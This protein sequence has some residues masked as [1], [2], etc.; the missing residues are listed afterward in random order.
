MSILHQLGAPFAQREIWVQLEIAFAS[1]DVIVAF[2]QALCVEA[3][4]QLEAW[5]RNPDCRLRVC[6]PGDELSEAGLHLPGSQIEIIDDQRWVQLIAG[7][8]HIQ[9]WS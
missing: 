4:A 9:H 5:A 8:T 3:L 2:D 7:H 1:G 6:I